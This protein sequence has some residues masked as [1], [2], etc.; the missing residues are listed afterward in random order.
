[1]KGKMTVKGEMMKE[2]MTMKE[3][4]VFALFFFFLYI[5]STE[6]AENNINNNNVYITI[7]YCPDVC[8]FCF[9]K[10][11][12]KTMFKLIYEKSI[13]TLGAIISVD[14]STGNFSLVG[15]FAW[16]QDVS[17]SFTL[18]FIIIIIITIIIIINYYHY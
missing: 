12:E 17:P 18:I 13:S 15:K 8:L 2:K 9:A 5:S 6:A 10:C 7:A 14:S 4:S 1:M 3:K 11:K 16:P